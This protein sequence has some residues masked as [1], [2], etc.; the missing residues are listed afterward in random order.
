MRRAKYLAVA[1]LAILLPA[2]AAMASWYDDY[3]AG[4]AAARK[5]DWGTA[6]ARMTSSIK[7]N[8]KE[9]NNTRTYGAIFINYHPYYYRGVAYLN[10]GKF[11]Q[12]IGDF[13]KTQGPG[14]TDLG[15]LETL[16]QRAKTKLESAQAAPENP[17]PTPAP[18]QPHP[19]TPSPITPSPVA[20]SVPSMDAGLRQR[21]QAAIENAQ[22]HLRS[23]QQRKATGSPQYAQALQ[24]VLG[25]NT[26][27]ASA[28]TN[29]DL[30][31]VLAAAQNAALLADSATAPGLPPNPTPVLTPTRPV[32]AADA[33]L[34]QTKERL[35]RA[36]EKYFA[37]DFE[38]ATRGFQT[39]SQELPR[40]GWIWAFLG[41]SQYSQFAFEAD[42]N[43][44]SAAMTS[45]RKAKQYGRWNRGLPEKYFSRRIRKAFESAL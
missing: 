31:N 40:N 42:D 20:P 22:A 13:E 5:G 16:M 8:P 43:Y 15:P 32:A 18:V 37:G 26:G 30:N 3:D 29:D 25:A 19:I 45:F 35:R 27:L 10:T 41:A 21:V 1:F 23:A 11:E 6:I 12:A 28:K 34:G 36:L 4:T 17:G 14:D 9:G 7:G 39:L 44:K 24:S 33:A 38:E 2:S